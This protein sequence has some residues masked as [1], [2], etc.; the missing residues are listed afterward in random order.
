M[1][2]VLRY[3]HRP[4]RDKRVTTHVALV[5]RAFGADKIVVDTKDVKLEETVKSI[6]DRFGGKFQIETG[7]N[8]REIIRNCGSKIIHLTMYGENIDGIIDK[9]PRNE[10]LLII[11]GSEK[12]PREFYDRADFNIAIGNQPHSEIAAVA[13]FLDRYYQRKELKTDFGGKLKIIGC[14][15]GKI[16]VDTEAELVQNDNMET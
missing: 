10:D 9:I 11:V 13:L 2:T 1:I 4:G 5:S 3:G 14:Q 8:W 12:V 6:I 15:K 7:V 16:V